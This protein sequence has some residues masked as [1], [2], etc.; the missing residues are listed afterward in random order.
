VV[1]LGGEIESTLSM[2]STHGAS[3]TA[4]SKIVL[5]IFSDS[6]FISRSSAG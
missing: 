1:F 3:L 6:P 4:F 5:T 2:N